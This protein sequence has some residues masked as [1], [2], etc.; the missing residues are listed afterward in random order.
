MILIK[1]AIVVCNSSSFNDKKVDLL[2]EN[3]IISQIADTIPQ[4]GYE[5]QVIEVEGLHVS[6]GWIDSGVSFGEPGFE[7]RQTIKNGLDAA[8]VGGF[9]AVM[10]VPN[11]EPN[12]ENAT[13]I[14]S[15]LGIKGSH[16]VNLHPIGSLTNNQEGKHLAELHDMHQAG[17]TSFY[18]FKTGLK[19]PN[20][21]KI[22]LQYSSS[23][24]TTIQSFPEDKDLAGNGMINEDATTIHTGLKSKPIMAEVARVAR[25]LTV[26]E[27]TG[28]RLHFPTISTAA[29]LDLIEKARDRDLNVSSS[30]SVNHLI[31]DSTALLEYDTNFKL[32]PPIRSHE[33]KESLLQLVKNGAGDMITSDH[34]ALNIELKAVEF[35][36][37]DYGSV[38]LETCFAALH[39]VLDIKDCVRLLTGAYDKFNIDQPSIA[40]GTTANLT[41][42]TSSPAGVVEQ[43][44]YTSTSRNAAL[45]GA[46]SKGT[47]VGIINNNKCVLNE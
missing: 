39:A 45:V 40:V 17:A 8:A 25:D 33:Q 42:F 19:D 36:H 22:A 32:Q 12:P 20:L 16:G 29:A 37:A 10:L 24:N 46:G 35:D 34:I 26:L 15:L 38:G 14:K 23:F 43:S 21:L 30:I 47:V 7:E 27:Y 44:M 28:G 41:L 3:G 5:T 1:Q 11:N 6:I 13:G 4:T 31:L 2:V 9:T 18:D